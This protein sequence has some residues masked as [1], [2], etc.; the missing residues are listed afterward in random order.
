MKPS[1]AGSYAKFRCPLC[2]KVVKRHV[3][4]GTRSVVSWCESK[5]KTVQLT[6]VKDSEI[7]PKE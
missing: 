5:S 1:R 6:R 4:K 3:S 7:K 2:E